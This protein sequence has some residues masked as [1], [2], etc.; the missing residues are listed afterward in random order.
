MLKIHKN[1]EVKILIGKDAGKSGKVVRIL[2][3]ERKVWVEGIN[4]YKRHV[5]KTQGMEGGV[6][7]ISKPVDISNVALVCPKCKKETRVGFK[8]DGSSKLRVCRKCQEVIS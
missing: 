4:M 2:P 5:K 3:N 6:I 8:V 7:D 1:D